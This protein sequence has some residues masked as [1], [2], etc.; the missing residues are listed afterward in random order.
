MQRFLIALLSGVALA[1]SCQSPP[2]IDPAVRA[3]EE[4]EARRLREAEAIRLAEDRARAEAERQRQLAEARAKEERRRQRLREYEERK[5]RERAAKIAAAQRSEMEKQAKHR[6]EVAR[7]KEPASTT[8]AV[9]ALFDRASRY[10]TLASEASRIKSEGEQSSNVNFA[11]FRIGMDIQDAYL[12]ARQTFPGMAWNTDIYRGNLRILIGGN[13][14]ID[15]SGVS[16]FG[17][18]FMFA[19]SGTDVSYVFAEADSGNRLVSQL[20]IPS[21]ISKNLFGVEGSVSNDQLIRTVFRKL[22]LSWDL[23]WEY[24]VYQAQVGAIKI[25]GFTKSTK[26]ADT[27]LFMEPGDIWIR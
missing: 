26:I 17:D 20:R 6:S 15:T 18:A 21:G 25:W 4:A 1:T 8:P 16:D 24:D 2:K 7:S 27:W 23:D 9:T 5:S 11:G 3:R 14:D 12:L 22:N 19:F 10:G 13:E